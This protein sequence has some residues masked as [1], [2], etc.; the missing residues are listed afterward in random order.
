MNEVGQMDLVRQELEGTLGRINEEADDIRRLEEMLQ[1]PGKQL[2]ISYTL[3]FWSNI[4]IIENCIFVLGEDIAKVKKRLNGIIEELS[5]KIK[6]LNK[7][8]LGKQVA[9]DDALKE[10]DRLLKMLQGNNLLL[11]MN[12]CYV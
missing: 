10:K 12:A 4:K 8:V 7:D 9:L 6:D 11:A 2:S 1:K 3:I 5:G